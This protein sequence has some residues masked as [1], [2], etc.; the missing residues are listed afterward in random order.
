MDFSAT[1]KTECCG[2]QV[3]LPQQTGQTWCGDKKQGEIVA[4]GYAQVMG[5]D[6]DET[7]ELVARLESIRILLAYATHHGF[8][9]VQIDIKSTFLSGPIK[10]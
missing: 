2:Y 5:L 6:F 3:G 7:F 1:F 9:L 10:E 4:K 8:K